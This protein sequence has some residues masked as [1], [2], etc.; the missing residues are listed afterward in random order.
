M[1][2]VILFIRSCFFYL[3]FYSSLLVCA[4]FCLSIGPFLSLSGRYR[5]FLYWNGFV[6]FWLKLCC[7]VKVNLQGQENIPDYALVILSNHQSSWETIFLYRLFSPVSAIL[8]KEL[9]SIPFF[10]WS[11]AL[12]KPIAID[13][14]RKLNARQAILNQGKDHLDRNISILIFPEGTRVGPGQK[15]TYQSGGAVLAI[16]AGANVLPVSHNAGLCWP[17][18]VFIK[19][20]GTI[21]V[22]IGKPIETAGRAARE[23]TKEVENWIKSAL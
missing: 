19:Y 22:R 10:G 21:T 11:L 13:R 8:K 3:G 6:L 15:K 5:Y 7:G 18:K 16:E 4:S 23:L 2:P 1:L 12:L 17:S 20:P 14:K 9:L